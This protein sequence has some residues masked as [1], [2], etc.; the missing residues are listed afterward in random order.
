[1][2]SK[3]DDAN[4]L[5][6]PGSAEWLLAKSA[7]GQN[8]NPSK[9]VDTADKNV[10]TIS[11][12]CPV[13]KWNSYQRQKL[14][15]WQYVDSK[16][17]MFPT[18]SPIIAA[19]HRKSEPCFGAAF[20]IM[21]LNNSVKCDGVSLF[22]SG[23]RWLTFAYGCIGVNVSQL[24][25]ENGKTIKFREDEK[26]L[27]TRIQNICILQ[28]RFSSV[29]YNQE[30]YEAVDLLFSSWSKSKASLPSGHINS[31]TIEDEL[32]S[33][34]ENP[35]DIEY[36]TSENYKNDLLLLV[37]RKFGLKDD[38]NIKY[39]HTS[40]GH[41]FVSTVA[42]MVGGVRVSAKGAKAT[43]KKKADQSAAYYC[44]LKLSKMVSS[45][46]K[47]KEPNFV[48]RV[49]SDHSKEGQTEHHL[50]NMDKTATATKLAPKDLILYDTS[51]DYKGGLKQLLLT[52]FSGKEAESVTFTVKNE[53]DKFSCIVN[54]EIVGLPVFSFQGPTTT[55]KKDAK[56]LVAYEG[57]CAVMELIDVEC[58]QS[59]TSATV[60]P[61]KQKQIPPI[62]MNNN[63]APAILSK[64]YDVY[65]FKINFCNREQE[66]KRKQ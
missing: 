31:V 53:K 55:S 61:N 48:D 1:M 36:K 63:L 26:E 13:Q 17:V 45:S 6:V 33:K 58:A 24:F 50:S 46:G 7:E 9:A 39:S 27:M 16:K 57:Y 65:A 37:S 11:S 35:A 40:I 5:L 22:P 21:G 41:E 2:G 20:Q 28:S 43:S 15:T 14:Q 60:N 38:K 52:H 62:P 64:L 34:L 8:Q 44:L 47:K 29:R 59:K 56:R 18:M 4:R 54:F 49:K 12:N 51:F 30:L 32:D 25:L 23:P 42:L 19:Y 66:E 10:I 3:Q